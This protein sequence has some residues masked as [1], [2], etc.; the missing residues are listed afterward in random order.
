[1]ATYTLQVHI[2]L[3]LE[4]FSRQIQYS[5]RHTRKLGIMRFTVLGLLGW[6]RLVACMVTALP[7]QQKGKP[8]GITSQ[9][10]PVSRTSTASPP[11]IT[12]QKS[13]AKSPS[14]TR[15]ASPSKQQKVKSKTPSKKYDS[16]TEKAKVKSGRRP[17]SKTRTG[18][19]DSTSKTQSGAAKTKTN[20]KLSQSDSVNGVPTFKET[21]TALDNNLIGTWRHVEAIA[22][23][24]K[25]GTAE[26]AS[27]RDPMKLQQKAINLEN[28]IAS[29]DPRNSIS[30]QLLAGAAQHQQAALNDV[31]SLKL[32][33]V[34]P[35]AALLETT[36]NE[37]YNVV[38]AVQRAIK[39][40]ATK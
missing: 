5:D 4:R 21:L 35:N 11:S 15:S 27:M 39:W 36:E 32:G 13:R 1:M 7:A 29:K 23:G 12:Q 8:K 30:Q 33:T 28:S 34:A 37:E 16:G 3:Q 31:D 17:T 6:L 9:P 19:L 14:Q 25:L 38:K 2:Q 10:K 24:E 26:V 20:N 18:S 40:A 22:K